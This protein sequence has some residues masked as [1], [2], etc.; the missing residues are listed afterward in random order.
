MSGVSTEKRPQRSLLAVPGLAI[1]LLSAPAGAA[2][3]NEFSIPT[4]ASSPAGITPG[5]DGE[6]WFTEYGGGK[7]G[8]ITTAGVV[9]E[10]P[11]AGYPGQIT[12]GPDGNLWFTEYSGVRI[13]Q[14][15]LSSAPVEL[16]SF[17]V[18]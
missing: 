3:I 13:G 9:T 17:G 15:I 4:A 1:A 18:D 2:T 8:R 10:F 11:T 7:I 6:L 5:P 12:S 16:M 14:L